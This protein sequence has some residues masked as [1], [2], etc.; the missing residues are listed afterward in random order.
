MK[1]YSTWIISFVVLFLLSFPVNAQQKKTTKK[2]VQ[3]TQQKKTPKKAETKTTL[4][5]HTV[6][7]TEDEKRVNDIIIFLQYML[8]TLGS[9]TTSTRDKEVLIKESYSKIFRDDKVQVEDDL[10]EDRIV[11]TN[12][13]IVPYLKD[14]EFFFQEVKFEFAIEDITS[15]TLTGGEIFYKVSTRRTLTGTTTEGKTITNTIP[16]Y[17]EIN[18]DPANQDLRIVSL[19]THEVNENMVLT[20]WWHDLSLEWKDVLIKKLPGKGVTDSLSDA[21]NLTNT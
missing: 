15:S 10:D 20:N 13:D 12:K 8:N 4:P 19:Y 21:L 9:S 16:R 17:V 5:A 1:R 2:P 6:N 7:A 11:I 3:K 14:V 18:Y